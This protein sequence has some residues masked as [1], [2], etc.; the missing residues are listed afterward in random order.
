VTV[1]ES[2]TAGNVILKVWKAT[3]AA[4]CIPIATTVAKTVRWIAI[5]T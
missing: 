2:G 1:A 4:D 3:S 5:G